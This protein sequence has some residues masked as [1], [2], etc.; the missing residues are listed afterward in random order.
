MP[1]RAD[2]PEAG[3]GRTMPSPH[4]DLDDVAVPQDVPA[5]H[6]LAVEPG[7]GPADARTRRTR[8]EVVVHP[9]GQVRDGCSL[10]QRKG[11]VVATAVTLRVDAD[12]AGQPPDRL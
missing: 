8:A 3:R 4:D 2:E 10:S 1:P 12:Q 7:G 9:V 11:L 6:Q 5:A